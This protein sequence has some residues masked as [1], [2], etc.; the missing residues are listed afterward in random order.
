MIFVTDLF[1]VGSIAIKGVA[2]APMRNSLAGFMKI[3]GR[4]KK[5]ARGSFN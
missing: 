4:S 3:F 5:W 2:H 1:V